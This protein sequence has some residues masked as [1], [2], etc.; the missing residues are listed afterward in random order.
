VSISYLTCLEEF[1]VCCFDSLFHLGVLTDLVRSIHMSVKRPI[2]QGLT[3]TPHTNSRKRIKPSDV[4]QDGSYQS[5]S[6]SSES[7]EPPMLESDFLEDPHTPI[8]ERVVK[9]PMSRFSFAEAK[10]RLSDKLRSIDRVLPRGDRS[11][12]RE[13]QELSA[14]SARA[15]SSDPYV[16]GYSPVPLSAPSILFA[17]KSLRSPLRFASPPGFFSSNPSTPPPEYSSA[18]MRWTKHEWKL[19]YGCLHEL[20]I[21][22][23]D[24]ED[25]HKILPDWIYIQFPHFSRS[26]VELRALAIIKGGLEHTGWD[27]IP[28]ELYR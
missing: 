6:D 17:P 12:V 5:D 15:S 8:S 1:A 19:L 28:S 3:F 9:T 13:R 14:K 23:I 21:E 18:N 10:R 24:Q 11:E 20:Q 7:L 2:E 16:S 26:E 27:N 22:H 4:G 25:I